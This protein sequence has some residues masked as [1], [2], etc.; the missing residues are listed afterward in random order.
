[1]EEKIQFRLGIEYFYD[2]VTLTFITK[3][4]YCEVFD[5]DNIY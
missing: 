1:M 4:K 2:D 3:K 5:A